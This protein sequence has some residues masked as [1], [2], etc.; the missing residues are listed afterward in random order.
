MSFQSEK[1]LKKS[2]IEALSEGFGSGETFLIDEFEYANGRTDLVIG[3]SSEAYL[4]RR[5]EILGISDSISDDL[6]L[7]VFLQLHSKGQITREH[8]YDV[9]AIDKKEKE[10]ALG[11][12]IE[13]GFVTEK[14]NKLS[15]AKSLRRHVTTSYAIELKLGKWKKALEQA[16]RGKSYADYQF[17]ALAEENILRAI[18]NIELF[19]ENDVGLM[20]ISKDREF[21]VHY[22]PGK[23]N[24]YSPMNKWRL[25]ETTIREGV[26]HS[27]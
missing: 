7:Q 27:D 18:E 26:N 1:E 5:K 12:L 10:D 17:V 20:E 11:W 22:Q 23:Q 24:P 6:Y 25:N 14:G 15:T 21:H 19:E 13:H 4:E 16:I 2:A 9:G 3:N 8:F